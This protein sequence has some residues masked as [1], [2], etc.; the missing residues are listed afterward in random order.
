M[1]GKRLGIISMRGMAATRTRGDRSL[2]GNVEEALR[3]VAEAEPRGVVRGPHIR[4]IGVSDDEFV[5]RS[6]R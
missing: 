4:Y 3:R 1:L 2:L 6:R 5:R